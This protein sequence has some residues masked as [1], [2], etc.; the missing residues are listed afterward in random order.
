MS[1]DE[2]RLQS[3]LDDQPDDGL[4][5]QAL[6]DLLEERGDLEAA[7]GQRWLAANRKWPDSDLASVGQTGWHWWAVG[8]DSPHQHAWLPPEVQDRMPVGEWLYATRVEAEAVLARALARV[9]EK[10]GPT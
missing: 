5:R 2:A 7:R 8:H 6:A 9:G 4:C 10:E 1:E 3:H